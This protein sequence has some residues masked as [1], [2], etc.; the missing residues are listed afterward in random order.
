MKE[1]ET[2]LFGLFGDP[3]GHSLSPCLQNEAFRLLGVDGVYLKFRVKREDLATA[4]AAV[5]CLNFAGVNLTIPHKETVISYLDEL[6]GDARLTGSVNTVVPAGG[7]LIGYS[8]DGEGFLL[9]LRQEAKVE[10]AGKRVVILGAGGAARALA[11]RLAQAEV[12]ALTLVGRDPVKTHSLVKELQG[13]TG[14][15]AGSCTFASPCLTEIAATADLVVNATPLGMSPDL[16]SQPPFPLA[17]CPADCLV[18]DLVYNPL[19]TAFLKEA[20][21]R[22]LKTLSGLGM[23]VYQGI[24]ACQLWTGKLP[25]FAPLYRLLK[26]K[27]TPRRD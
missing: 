17:A 24:L 10:P 19:E 9:S 2:C 13:K 3:V 15:P 22:G 16:S 11:F 6:A 7:K 14:F 27:L 1:K 18:A 20:R 5:R 26:E 4:M 25:P 12:G 21:R 23:L 8:T